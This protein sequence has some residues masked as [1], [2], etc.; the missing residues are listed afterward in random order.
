LCDAALVTQVEDVLTRIGLPT[1][2]EGLDA[3]AL[4]AAMSTDKKWMG[5]KSRFVLLRGIGQPMIVEDVP[6]REVIG[7]MQALI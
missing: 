4:Y 2:M 5:G 3:E 6:K 7:V 1:R